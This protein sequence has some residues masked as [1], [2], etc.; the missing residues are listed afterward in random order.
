[1]ELDELREF[2]LRMEHELHLHTPDDTG[3][4]GACGERWPCMPILAAA[5]ALDVKVPATDPGAIMRTNATSPAQLYVRACRALEAGTM[6]RLRGTV[7]DD[8]LDAVAGVL[9]AA[10]D[11]LVASVK[12]EAH[13]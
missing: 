9:K 4:C 6:D 13:G 10:I 7:T 3:A 1:M 11:R 2:A 8:D 5:R 12:A